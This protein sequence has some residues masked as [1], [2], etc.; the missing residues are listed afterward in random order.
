M[1]KKFS[2][3]YSKTDDDKSN[4]IEMLYNLIIGDTLD[5]ACKDL[6]SSAL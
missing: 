4:F 2:Y 1:I 3:D 6:L 5:F